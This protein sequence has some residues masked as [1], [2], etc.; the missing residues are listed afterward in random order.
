[1][2]LAARAMTLPAYESFFA[3]WLRAGQQ[4]HA[5]EAPKE[6]A[7]LEGYQAKFFSPEDFAALQAF[8]EILIPTDDTPGAREARCASFID[9]VLAASTEYAP[10]TQAQWRRAMS[11]LKKQG[12]HAA[13]A[14]TRERMVDE[15]S[16]LENTRT[17]GNE[18][19]AAFRL[20]KR[21]NTFAFYTSREGMIDTLD[22][23]GDSYNL[24][25]PACN[26]PEHHVI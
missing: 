15:L 1:M 23:R 3:E 9:F 6:P 18:M 8:T 5:S 24:T 12:F 16:R 13:D 17:A 10:Q 26:H 4:H 21:E 11:T 22:Y 25:F 14:K 7:F 2:E 19:L 20:I